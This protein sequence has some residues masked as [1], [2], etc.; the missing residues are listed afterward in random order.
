MKAT[1]HR[2]VDNARNALDDRRLQQALGN[3]TQTFPI[4]RQRVVDRL[5]EF[6]ALRDL[7]VG[8]KNHVLENLDFYLE[9]FEAKV[10]ETG[11]TVHWCRD[12]TE[13]RD[14][15][16]ALCQTAGAKT[17][18]KSKSMIGEEIAINEHLEKHGI[19]AIET[20]LGEYIIQIRNESP[21][22]ILVP[23]IHLSGEDIARTFQDKHAELPPD[24]KLD[25]PESILRE[26]R[27]VLREK[28][29][30]ADVGLTGA[31]MLVAETGSVVV[32]TNEG[33][34]DLIMGL[35]KTH[36]VLASIEKVV[37]TLEDAA[38]ILRLLSRSATGQEITAYTSFVTGPKRQD[39][40]DG[41]DTYHVILLDNGRTD[42]LADGFKE[43]LRCIRCGACL[44]HCPVYASVGGHAYGWVYSGP[45]GKVLTPNLLGAKD[46]ADL[47]N[48]STFCGKCQEV[49]P[50]RIPLPDLMRR[51][52]ERQFRDRSPVV[53]NRAGMKLWAWLARR[54]ALYGRVMSALMGLLALFGRRRGRFRRLPLAGGWTGRRD[55]PAPEG[56][57]FRSLW[58]ERREK[59]P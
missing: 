11:G 48:A 26:A 36:I 58:A 8:I 32:V 12:A 57:T 29:L 1:S 21:S 18:A 5:P 41:P 23:A 51:W 45:M 22:H 35:P 15:I 30:A 14:T 9:A 7:A 24:R 2:F 39:E 46:A 10:I 16:L 40:P 55:F 6:D 53:E 3:F 17:V 25:E 20:D 56:R 27:A 28:F 4:K 49:C 47:P 38:T 50:M 34:A 52:R 59:K 44:N 43:M 37:P 13:A 33:N 42:M 31:N 19:E 54:P